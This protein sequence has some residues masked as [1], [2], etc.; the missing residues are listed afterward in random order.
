VSFGAARF[1]TGARVF[2]AMDFGA[3]DFGAMD[4]AV[5]DFAVMD[6]AVM[7][8]GIWRAATD[9]ARAATGVTE[10]AACNVLFDGARLDSRLALRSRSALKRFATAVA[11][12]RDF[13]LVTTA[14]CR[15]DDCGRGASFF[16]G[17]A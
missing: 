17:D 3:M 16:A 9:A 7:D 2:G 13:G 15:T 6:F 14:F 10:R 1:S 8:F 4:F 11:L 12:A 5:M